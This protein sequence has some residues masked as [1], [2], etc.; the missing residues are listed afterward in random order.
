MKRSELKKLM[1]PLIKEC[2]RESLL[3]EGILSGVISEVVKGLSAQ[4]VLREQRSPPQTASPTLDDPRIQEIRQQMEHDKRSLL[5]SF[6]QETFNGINI[7]E[8]T[9]AL[10][11]YESAG[12][13]T[14]QGGALSGVDPRDPG[15]D[16]TNIVALGG[17]NWKA[18]MG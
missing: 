2:I 9:E 6:K 7:F 17:K 13:S 1:K 10:T 12:A 5:D 15:V 8:G 14:Q 18:L 11:D 3:E 16:I 4:P